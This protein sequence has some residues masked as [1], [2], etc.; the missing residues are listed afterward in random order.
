VSFEDSLGRA[1][2]RFDELLG[3][4]GLESPKEV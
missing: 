4:L 3:N 1:Q 2:V